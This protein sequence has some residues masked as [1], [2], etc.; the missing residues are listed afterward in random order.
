MCTFSL[1]HLPAEPGPV[2]VNLDPLRSRM[3]AS[4]LP[5][6]FP[7]ILGLVI[8]ATGNVVLHVGVLFTY[9]RTGESV[10]RSSGLRQRG[11][12]RESECSCDYDCRKFQGCVLSRRV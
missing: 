3:G 7:T 2:G 8:G 9:E 10:P 5:E 11:R 1:V 4:V 12:A 6:A